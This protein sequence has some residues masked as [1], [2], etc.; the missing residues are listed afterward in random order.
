MLTHTHTS[1]FKKK[2][3]QPN[4]SEWDWQMGLLILAQNKGGSR[5]HADP[6]AKGSI[7]S[8]T[9]LQGPHHRTGALTRWRGEQV[10][11]CGPFLQPP[12]RGQLAHSLLTQKLKEDHAT[13]WIFQY[14][15]E[16]PPPTPLF[17]Y[18]FLNATS[19]T[20]QHPEIYRTGWGG[21]WW[22]GISSG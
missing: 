18:L 14:L 4:P 3:P 2:T 9:Y 17:I 5:L 15:L 1:T 6:S 7:Q 19:K 13:H 12:S 10:G 11:A 22:A 8:H 21:V 16:I 20:W